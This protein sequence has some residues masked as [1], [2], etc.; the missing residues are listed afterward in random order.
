M[1]PCIQIQMVLFFPTNA[2]NV[3][4]PRS[5][6]WIKVLVVYVYVRALPFD[7]DKNQL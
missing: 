4:F 2:S 3:S 6:I 1:Y 5:K 7:H